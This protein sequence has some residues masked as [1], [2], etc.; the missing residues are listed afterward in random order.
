MQ[1]RTVLRGLAALAA[2]AGAGCAAD[3][4]VPATAPEP[5]EGIAT[6]EEGGDG[7]GGA[8]GGDDGDAE[9]TPDQQRFVVPA[10]TFR[11][12]ENG[13]LLVEV[14]VRNR[15]GVAHEAVMTVTVEA[16]DRTF[17]PS[18][19]VVLQPQASGLVEISFPIPEG[20]LT[21]FA[22]SFDPGP[23]ET[24]IPDGTV[25]PYPEDG[26]ATETRSRT[27]RTDPT[28]TDPA[29]T[30]PN[31]SEAMAGTS[32]ETARSTTGPDA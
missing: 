26:T 24:P 29:A 23:P 16:G 21:G 1:R 30:D 28:A 17:S 8:S 6:P 12:D 5:P 9:P 14:T 19:H 27:D 20:R 13:D 31:A 11:S 4:E 22:I 10:R 3:G 25:T 7:G 18:R 15:V 2:G 32:T